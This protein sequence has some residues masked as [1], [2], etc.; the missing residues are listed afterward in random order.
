CQRQF[1]PLARHLETITSRG[2]DMLR[3]RHAPIYDVLEVVTSSGRAYSASEIELRREE[4][5]IRL[6]PNALSGAGIS[7]F[8]QPARGAFPES[9]SIRVQY[10]T[11]FAA[12][13]DNVPLSQIGAEAWNEVARVTTDAEFAYF[14]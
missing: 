5:V 13:G 12:V 6:R 7:A 3:L 10:R 14:D 2:S 11:G 9:A 4:G 8:G 1:V